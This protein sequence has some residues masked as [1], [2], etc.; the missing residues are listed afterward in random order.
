[1]PKPA[2]A[3]EHRFAVAQ[4]VGE[5]L[6]LLVIA[7][8]LGR[9]VASRGEQRWADGKPQGEFPL[10]PRRARRH[11]GNEAKR[12]PKRDHGL[13]IGEAAHRLRPGAFPPLDRGVRHAGLSEMVGHKTRL[14]LSAIRKPVGETL[15]DPPVK[16]LPT[17]H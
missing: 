1:V 5:G 8:D 7:L 6:R 16:E 11:V 14:L 3:R 12:I 17:A 2:R 9:S 13:G 15:R 4:S 10:V